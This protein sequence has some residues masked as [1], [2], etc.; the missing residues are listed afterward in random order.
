MRRFLLWMKRKKIDNKIPGAHSKNLFLRDPKGRNHY[1]V[2]LP[3]RK[4]FDLKSFG[5]L[6][7]VRL[8]FASPERLQKYLGLTPGSVSPFRLDK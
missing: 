3:A 7:G 2:V 1:L 6:L 8:S 4:K 5:N